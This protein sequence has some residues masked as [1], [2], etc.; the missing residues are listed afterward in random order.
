VEPFINAN[1]TMNATTYIANNS[2]ITNCIVRV[3]NTSQLVFTPSPSILPGPIRCFAPWN[4]DYWR[5]A[6]VWNVTVNITTSNGSNKMTFKSFTYNSLKASIII[7]TM[8]NFTGDPGQTVQSS[9]AFPMTIKN[10][11]NEIYNIS[12]KGTDYI[13][14]SNNLF[15]IK[16]TNSTIN[17]TSIGIFTPLIYSLQTLYIDA[18]PRYVKEIYF[19]TFIPQSIP[20]QDY[21][22]NVTILI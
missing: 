11:G 7:P 9:N 2:L 8:I 22:A 3:Y 12:I 16:V 14:K 15:R 5:N 10:V 1:V 19:K 21:E 17:Q 18:Y 4:M 6:G 20:S 13:G